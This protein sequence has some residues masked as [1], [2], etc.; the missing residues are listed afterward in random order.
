MEG[1]E[2]E[3]EERKRRGKRKRI[4]DREQMCVCA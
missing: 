2:K 1:E 3:W 4:T